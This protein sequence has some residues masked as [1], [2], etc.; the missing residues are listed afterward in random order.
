MKNVCIVGGLRSFIGVEKG[1]YKHLAA[2][3]IG[4]DVV[5]ALLKK[6]PVPISDIDGIIMGNSVGG[7]GNG[8]RLLTLEAG[9]PESIPALTVDTQ[10]GSG[11]EAMA[12]A[13][14]KIEAG[15]GNVFIA[16]GAESC[17]TKPVRTRSENHPDYKADGNNIY[18]VAKF[19]PGTPDELTMFRGAEGVAVKWQMQKD[20]LDMWA[21]RSHRL[22]ADAQASGI[23]N[24]IIIA[25]HM[26]DRDK[27][28]TKDETI[29]PKISEK[30][31]KRLQPLVPGGKFITAGNACLTQDGAAFVIIC[32]K[33]Y[34]YKHNLHVEAELVDVLSVGVDPNFSPAST[35]PVVEKLLDRNN[36]SVSDITAWE[37][38]EAFAVID[39][40]A[41]RELGIPEQRYN[42]FG[43]AIAY[44]H[45]YGAS[46]GI[47]TLHLLKALELL[48]PAQK[49]AY[50]ICSI[51]AAGGIGT[52][53]L[54]RKVEDEL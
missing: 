51:A 34:A 9:L 1:M 7:C 31:L 8:A 43:G 41:T 4:A 27:D 5:K 25:P 23:L 15:L 28:V 47:I 12:I 13:A 3:E 11:L 42:I 44:G 49:E 54:V 24:D 2:E 19:V 14:A 29:R 10:C 22:A 18:N 53:M 16:G 30:L 26:R 39:I 46:G 36:L 32:S 20:E 38:N 6:F 21:L 37:F 50:G 52:A 40:L 48:E 17:S 45:P 33:E 35:V